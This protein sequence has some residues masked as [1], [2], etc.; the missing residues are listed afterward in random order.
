MSSV[1]F[2]ASAVLAIMHREDGHDK[3]RR[4][5]EGAVI[6]A[7]NYSEVLKKAVEAGS[8]LTATR[9][10]LENFALRIVPFDERLAVRTAELWS[11]GRKFGLSFAD[12]ACLALGMEHKAKVLTGDKRWKEAGLDV[13]VLL[14]R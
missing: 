7:V 10:H 3:A 4:H 9:Y 13:A 14:F 12:R 8:N 2:D 1:V 11:A 5:L 6:S